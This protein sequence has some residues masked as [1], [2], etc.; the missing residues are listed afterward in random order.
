MQTRS[1]RGVALLTAL[2]IVALVA[3]LGVGMLTHMN[4]ALH[5]GGN[6]WLSQQALQY[7]RGVEAWVAQIL[8]R[9]RENNDTDTLEEVWA[10]PVN[11]LPV[12]AGVLS[13]QVID[14]QGRFNVNNLARGDAQSATAGFAR[15]LQYAAKVDPVTA[16]AIAQATR[17]WGDPDT[18]PTGAYGAEDAYYLGLT[19]AYRCANRPIVSV[20]ALRAVRGMQP[21]IYRALR[22]YV[23]ALPEATSINVNTASAP[24]LA[25]LAKDLDPQTIEQLLKIRKDDPWNSVDAFLREDALAGRKLERDQISVASDWFLAQGQVALGRIKLRFYS[26]LHRGTRGQ[27]I[28]VRHGRNAF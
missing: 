8:R 1:Q 6:L 20:T 28:I 21:E 12:E 17:D 2:L 26:L 27:T 3:T 13:G 7:A 10:Q 22:P 4:F 23:T 15:L 16:Q 14:L 9:D 18:R 25:S 19:P 11:Y 5:R 24:V